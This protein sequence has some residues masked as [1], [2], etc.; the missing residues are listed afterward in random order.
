MSGLHTWVGLLPAWILYFMFITGA[1]SYFKVEITSWMEPEIP[2]AG[3]AAS[4]FQMVEVAELY[5]IEHAVKADEWFVGLPD[6]RES[7]IRLFW[8]QELNEAEQKGL[9]EEQAGEV[10]LYPQTGLPIIY[11]NNASQV[12]DT[13]G[14][15]ALYQMHFNLRYFS[16]SNARYLVIFSTLFMLVGLITGIVIHKKIFK[17]FFTFRPG[18]KHRSWLD[19]HNI[20]SVLTLPFLLMITYSGLLY[21][22]NLLLPVVANEPFTLASELDFD[23]PNLV[24]SVKEARS[25]GPANRVVVLQDNLSDKNEALVRIVADALHVNIEEFLGAEEDEAISSAPLLPMTILLQKAS[26]RWPHKI[27]DSISVDHPY[28]SNALVSVQFRNEPGERNRSELSYSGVSG[29]L[30][31]DIDNSFS[32]PERINNTLLGL[33]EARF[34]PI[35][36]RWLF[37]IT[38]LLGAGMIATGTILWTV[39]RRTQYQSAIEKGVARSKKGLVF[40]ERFNIGTIVGLPIAVAAYFWAN[41]LLPFNLT[42]RHEWEMHSLFIIWG[43]TFV[44]AIVRPSQRGWLELLCLAATSYALIPVLNFFTTDRHLGISLLQGDWLMA[45]FD[46]TMLVFGLIFG[47]AAF[48]LYKKE[49]TSNVSTLLDTGNAPVEI[50]SS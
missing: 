2:F 5:L 49:A 15:Q 6:N 35:V 46:L 22:T 44:W 34:S 32:V 7:F 8:E 16:R 30:I 31:E 29:E 13:G 19:M 11:G 1:A 39:K 14:G 42:E 45:G 33:H 18:K 17:E 37:F 26:L 4:Q 48:K 47:A 25:S 38:G 20:F 23:I 12:R 40:V 43:M 3:E 28:K 21:F 50:T 27:I 10:V 24:T 41:R 9:P 36:V